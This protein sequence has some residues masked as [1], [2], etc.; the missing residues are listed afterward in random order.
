MPI[1]SA[2]NSDPSSNNTKSS[3][4][5]LNITSKNYSINSNKANSLGFVSEIGSQVSDAASNLMRFITGNSKKL[6][7]SSSTAKLVIL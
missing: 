6:T 1:T 3:S 5:S 2:L 7:S 4:T